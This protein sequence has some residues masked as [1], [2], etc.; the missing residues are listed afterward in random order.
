MGRDGQLFGRGEL[1]GRGFDGFVTT[2][3][4]QSG[5][6]Q[7]VSE[8]H[9]LYVVLRESTAG[10][11]FLS[12]S[13]GGWF[14]GKDPTVPLE[15]L[16]AKWVSGTPLVYAGRARKSLTY[17]RKSGLR[18][19]IGKL[20]K[21]GAGVAVAHWGGRYLWQVRGSEEFV[22]AWRPLPDAAS[23]ALEEANLLAEFESAFAKLPFAN[24]KRG[25]RS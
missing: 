6:L 25:D 19:R 24:M 18:Y 12:N 1:I 4:L 17:P 15:V 14:K 23:P 22:V 7:E 2:R 13:R 5:R 20:L 9:G 16:E 10:P 11:T 21:F 8:R 3:D